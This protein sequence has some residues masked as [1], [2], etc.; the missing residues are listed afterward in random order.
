MIGVTAWGYVPSTPTP[1]APTRRSLTRCGVHLKSHLSDDCTHDTILPMV[2]AA[3]T[4][5]AN[6]LSLG[7]KGL[8]LPVPCSRVRLPWGEIER[9]K[10]RCQRRS[11]APAPRPS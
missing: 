5:Y 11:P 8:D 1:V 7:L 9:W 10:S 4:G 2:F 3:P 6:L